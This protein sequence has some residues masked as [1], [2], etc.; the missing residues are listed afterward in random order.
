MVKKYPYL[1]GDFMWT[2]WDYLGEAGI[3]AWSYTGG[4]PFNRPYPWIL[5]GAGVIDILGNPDGSCKFASTVWGCTDAPQIAVRPVNHPGVRPSK[6]SWRGTNAMLSWSWKGCD[7]NMATVEVYSRDAFVELQLNGRRTG[8]KKVKDYKVLFNIKYMPGTLTAVAFDEKGNET[9]R[10]SLVSAGVAH[11]A[12]H[13]EK[14]TVRPGE[15]V[16]VPVT[17]EDRHGIVESNADR[18]LS[19]SVEGGEPL[20]FGSANPC[21]AE[22][23]HTG[24]FTTYYGRALAIVRAGE[25]GE[26]KVSVADGEETAEAII[27]IE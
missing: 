3:G 8:R 21:T 14:E 5:A 9:G 27:E 4:M 6:S 13:P 10:S 26:I 12:I 24:T 17:I 11:A 20:A 23:Y 25:T 7:G 22:E 2:G 19:V 1:V 18:T 16:Y 15:I